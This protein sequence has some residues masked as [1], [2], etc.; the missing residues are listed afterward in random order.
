MTK[1]QRMLIARK[2][3]NAKMNETL[4]MWAGK[5]ELMT[6]AWGWRDIGTVSSNHD[7]QFFYMDEIV[8]I[9]KALGLHYTLTVG[10]NLDNRPTPFVSIF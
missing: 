3:I 9:C 4:E 6:Y 10:R 1:A 2:L 8:A 7:G 5:E